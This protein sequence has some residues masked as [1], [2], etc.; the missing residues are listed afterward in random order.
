MNVFCGASAPKNR[1]GCHNTETGRFLP[2]PGSVGLC[3]NMRRSLVGRFDLVQTQQ[4]VKLPSRHLS[5]MVECVFKSVSSCTVGGV[6]VTDSHE[7]QHWSECEHLHRN[8]LAM[9]L[10]VIE[11]LSWKES[12]RGQV[13]ADNNGL[14]LMSLRSVGGLDWGDRRK[15][16]CEILSRINGQHERLFS[17]YP[18]PWLSWWTGT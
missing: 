14:L 8:I 18:S 10:R 3:P 7:A 2:P 11:L 16:V 17:V 15:G 5:F 13:G 12:R 1:N 4:K 9:V 6:A